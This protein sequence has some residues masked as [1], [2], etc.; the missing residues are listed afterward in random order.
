MA[1]KGIEDQR[2]TEYHVPI[3][4]IHRFQ[5]GLLHFLAAIFSRWRYLSS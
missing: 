3:L 2:G 5:P 4:Q 1:Q